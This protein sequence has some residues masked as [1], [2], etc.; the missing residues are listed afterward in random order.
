MADPKQK[1]NDLLEKQKQV[2]EAQK[3]ASQAIQ[4]EREAVTS[5]ETVQPLPPAGQLQNK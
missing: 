3:A 4:K 2:I 1:I 5:S